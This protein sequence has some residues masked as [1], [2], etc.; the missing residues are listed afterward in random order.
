MIKKLADVLEVSVDDLVYG[1]DQEKAKA[2]IQ[3]SELLSMFSKAQQLNDTDKEA[4][5]AMLKAFIFQ[6]DMQQQ[7]AK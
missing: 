2:K 3:D 1:A 7:L 6:K 4:I 5:K